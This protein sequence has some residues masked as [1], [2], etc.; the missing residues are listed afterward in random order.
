MKYIASREN[1]AYKLI[2]RIASGKAPGRTILEGVH[3]CGAWLDHGKRPDLALFDENRLRASTELAELAARIDAHS[4][5]VCAPR[6]AHAVSEVEHGQGVIF[7][8]TIPSVEDSPVIDRNCVWLDR[9]QDPGN[10][11]TLLRTAAAAGVAH[12]YLSEGCARPWSQKTLRS[13]QGAHFALF[14]HEHQDLH[15]LRAR[16]AIPLIATAVRHASSIHDVALPLDC[17]WL[18]GHEGRGVAPDL[19]G[20][21]DQRV[22]IP[23]APGAESLNV[24]AAAAVCLFEQRRRHRC[25]SSNS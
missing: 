9:I 16:L 2:A 14:I 6:L 24:A 13:A 8:V 22:F 21:A 7:A 18:F 4:C 10:L 15:A 17:A 12:V 19:L 23:M 20:L 1:P 11:G 25:S 5:L 3:L